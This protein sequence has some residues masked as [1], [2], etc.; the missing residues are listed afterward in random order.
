MAAVTHGAVLYGYAL[1]FMMELGAL[2]LENPEATPICNT[3]V[4]QFDFSRDA[5]GK[6]VGKMVF[7]NRLDHINGANFS[8]KK[9]AAGKMYD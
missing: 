4:C 2:K 8:V 1:F 6:L 7:L 9:V 3:G 5:N